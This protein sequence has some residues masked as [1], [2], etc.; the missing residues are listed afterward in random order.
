MNT[1]TTQ[2]K[3]PAYAKMKQHAAHPDKPNNTMCNHKG[4]F[5]EIS[6]NPKL[7]D[8]KLCLRLSGWRGGGH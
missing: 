1:Q 3:K 7:V 6:T 2:K 4:W 5:V 8:C